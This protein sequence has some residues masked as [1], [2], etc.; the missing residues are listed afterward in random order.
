VQSLQTLDTAAPTATEYFP[1]PQ[2]TQELAVVAPVVVKY[3]PAWQFVHATVPVTSLNFPAAH[4]IH[5]PPLGPEKPALQTQLV[6]A[7]DPLT[8]C[9]LLV[10]ARQVL[11][12]AV[13]EYVLTPQS[14]HVEAS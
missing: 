1:A 9:E 14:R 2:P 4:T 10:Q 8:D 11:A 13:V 7:V 5:D 3:L 6:A 12:A